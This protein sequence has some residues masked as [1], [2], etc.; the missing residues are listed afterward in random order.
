MI[1]MPGNVHGGESIRNAQW[2]LSWTP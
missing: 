1:S 2:Q